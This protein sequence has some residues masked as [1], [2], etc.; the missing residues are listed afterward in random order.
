MQSLAPADPYTTEFEAVVESR[1]DD[2]LVLDETYCYAESGGQPPDRGTLAGERIVDVQERDGGIVHTLADAP[3]AEVG[4]TVAGRI[5][6]AFRT[7]CMRSHTASHVLYGAG[8]RLFDDLGYGGFDI[9]DHKVRVDFATPTTIDDA[10]LVALERL[11]NR[12]VWDSKDVTWETAP[13]E[14]AL[15][16]DDVA[17]NT[18][19]EE[20]I[21]GEEVRLVDV[22]GW[23]VAACGGTHVRNTREIGPVAVLDRSNPGEGVTRVEFAVGPAAIQR[24]SVEKTAALDA[25]AVLETRVTDL[26]DA[27]ARLRDERDAIAAERTGLQEELVDSRLDDLRE[28]VVERDG[29]AWLV[30]AVDH[31][32]TNELAERATDLAGDAADA[33]ALVAA[34]GEGV[35]VATDGETDASA[36]VDDFTAEFGGGGGGSETVAQA[37]G[38]DADPDDLVAFLRTGDDRT[39]EP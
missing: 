13:R 11:V 34:D 20:G 32:D 1:D 24:R 36:V 3:A 37:G 15:A 27:I 12:A 18:K 33:V 9:D 35:A 16:R 2:E 39:A 31:L 7:Y 10:T 19:T 21:G 14:T 22:D 23:D 17:F 29:R 38:F 6:P 25:A 5:D 8:R 28:T 26:P 4:E 30:G